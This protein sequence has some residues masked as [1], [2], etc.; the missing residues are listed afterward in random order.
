MTMVCQYKPIPCLESYTVA[1][2][3]GSEQAF[4]VTLQS[5]VG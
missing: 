2:Q 3:T 4:G 5:G 1:D